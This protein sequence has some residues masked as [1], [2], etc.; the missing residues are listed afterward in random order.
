ML[1]GDKPPP[2]Y[3]ETELPAS[4]L[5]EC[6]GSG[7]LPNSL[8][9]TPTKANGFIHVPVLYSCNLVIKLVINLGNLECIQV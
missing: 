6:L 1:E 9:Q 8:G 3:R 5:K 4:D 7:I 2:I